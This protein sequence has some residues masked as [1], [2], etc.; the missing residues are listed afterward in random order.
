MN[1][2]KKTGSHVHDKNRLVIMS[3]KN[4]LVLMSLAINR[5]VNRSLAK[6]KTAIKNKA[7]Y[8]MFEFPETQGS[9][10]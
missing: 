7:Y 1:L 3:D 6:N 10:L 8:G 5:L 2:T 4:R 9:H